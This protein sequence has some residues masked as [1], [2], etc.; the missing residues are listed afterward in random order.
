MIASMLQARALARTRMR[1]YLLVRFIWDAERERDPRH[2]R[3]ILSR[4]TCQA[5][6]CADRAVGADVKMAEYDVQEAVIVNRGFQVR[7]GPCARY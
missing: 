2:A 4:R 7:P 6:R 3:A 1:G 5:Q